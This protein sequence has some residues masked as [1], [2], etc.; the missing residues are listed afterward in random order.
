MREEE[1]R[2][3]DD[4]LACVSEQF[5]VDKNCVSSAGVSDG[6]LWTSQLIGGRGQYLSSA[7]VLS[8]GV[9][10]PGDENAMLVKE[11]LPSSHAMPVLVLWGGPTDICIVLT[12]ETASLALEEKLVAEG[13]F[14]LEC[15]H[16][17]GHSVPPIEVAP[18]GSLITPF[19][20]FIRSH[21]YWT[22]V[23]RSPYEADGVPADFPAWC[24]IGAGNA[25]ARTG[26]CPVGL[27]CP[28]VGM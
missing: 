8:G 3:F 23:G 7:V 21:P 2:F 16:N 27:G 10:N 18:G 6:A 19:V 28:I 12:F 26:E 4:M 5:P 14:I 15:Q 25:V 9:A 20:S 17:C 1:F 24:A 11:Y 22:P 13:H